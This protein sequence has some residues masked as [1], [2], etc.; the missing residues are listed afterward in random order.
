MSLSLTL[1]GGFGIDAGGASLP[2]AARKARVL[3]AALALARN[4]TLSRTRLASLLWGSSEPEQARV[5]LRQ[6]VAQVRRA[7]IELEA[8]EVDTL[9]LPAAELLSIAQ[10]QRDSAICL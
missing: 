6:A 3:I 1:L 9:T 5:S 2:L 8:T 10:R 4:R 7:G